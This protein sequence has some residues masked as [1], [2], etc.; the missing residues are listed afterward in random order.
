[1]R[2][3]VTGGTGLVGK[4]LCRFLTDNGH[5][6]I[7][8]TRKS[9]AKAEAAAGPKSKGG[10]VRFVRWLNDGDRPEKELKGIHA[11]VNLAGATINTRWTEEGKKRIIESRLQAGEEVNRIISAMENKPAILVNASAIGIYGTSLDHTFTERLDADGEDFLAYTARKWEAVAGKASD[12]GLR[13]VLCR[14]GVIL[15]SD[16]GALPRMAL[17]YRLFAGG[18][19]GSGRQ[20]ISW[21]HIE[22][23]V[24]GILFAIDNPNLAGPVNFTSPD[25]V[26]MKDFGRSLSVAIGKPHWLPV[27]TFALKLMLGEM[28]VLVLEGQKV[29]PKKLLEN[30]F[31]FNYPV[32]DQAL[33][34]IF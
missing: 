8:L 9:T 33:A 34:D 23:V 19:V 24:R 30:G 15:D 11:I 29:L 13:T 25:P 7:V 4:A 12:L 1:M 14:F 3:A 10:G 6:A 5:E 2:V 32:L 28:S 27:P 20:W 21:I 22:D 18:T 31:S 26:R 16:E 17:P